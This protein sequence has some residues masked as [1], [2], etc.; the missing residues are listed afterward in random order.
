MDNVIGKY[1]FIVIEKPIDE[2]W[3]EITKPDNEVIASNEV[4]DSEVRARLA[5]IG[6]IT[7]LENGPDDK[8]YL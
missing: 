2:F 1:K 4:F 8:E 6:H 5:A 7:K 3:Y